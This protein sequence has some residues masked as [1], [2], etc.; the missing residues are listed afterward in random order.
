[1]MVVHLDI[2]SYVRHNKKLFANFNYVQLSFTEATLKHF[3]TALICRREVSAIVCTI[4]ACCH[5]R[6]MFVY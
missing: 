5:E 6:L 2:N 4:G 1:M 3:V